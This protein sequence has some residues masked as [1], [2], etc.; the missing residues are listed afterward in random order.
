MMR[1]PFKDDS[2]VALGLAVI[3]V[4]L[5]GVMA[6]GLLAVVRSD[7]ES[8]VAAN[9]GQG[10]FWL[11]DAGAQAAAAQLR[12]DAD[13]EHYDAQGADNAQWARVSPD[14]APGKTL[15]L[16]P[17]TVRVSIL[18][19]IPS[20]TPGEQS[21]ELHAPELVP[22]GHTDYPDRDFFLVTSEGSAGGARRGI[23]AIICA[24]RAGDSPEITRWS[25]REVYG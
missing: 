17:G 24:R 2:G 15:V 7:L 20:Q 19:L 25:W 18:Y 12:A 11:A 22:P 4:V 16:E 9:R 1:L 10:A 13:P 5:L 23:E 14:G 3:L 6:A 8:V 21:D